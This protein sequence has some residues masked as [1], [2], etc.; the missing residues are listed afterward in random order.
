MALAGL[1]EMRRDTRAT[2]SPQQ[3]GS[4]RHKSQL[5]HLMLTLGQAPSSTLHGPTPSLFTQPFREGLLLITILL[6]GGRG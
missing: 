4:G 3:V 6:G 5:S 1:N 2:V